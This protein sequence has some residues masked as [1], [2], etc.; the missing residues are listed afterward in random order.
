MTDYK[1]NDC[2]CGFPSGDNPANCENCQLI[3]RI[4]SLEKLVADMREAIEQIVCTDEIDRGVILLSSEGPTHY[5]SKLQCLVYE[6]EHFSELGDAMVL[7]WQMTETK[8]T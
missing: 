6:R 1:P 7:L 5:D 8:A 3:A 4:R 2:W